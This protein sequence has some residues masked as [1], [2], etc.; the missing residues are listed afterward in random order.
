MLHQQACLKVLFTLDC[1]FT[2]VTRFFG[3]KVILLGL[4]NGQKLESE[5]KEDLI[6]Y[7]RAM[8]GDDSSFVRVVLL[9]GRMQGAV[10]IGDTG[11]EEAFENVILDGIDL[12][13]FG[14]RILDPDIEFD[15]IFD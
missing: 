15:H 2:H 10:L 14:P 6:A 7:S 3:K 4:Y 5:R 11:L 13:Q 12:S 8:E 1:Q 9:R